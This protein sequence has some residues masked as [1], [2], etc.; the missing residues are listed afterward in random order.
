MAT[1]VDHV[2]EGAKHIAE[3]K[4]LQK[5]TR[6]WMCCLVMIMVTI[7]FIIVMTVVKPW[8]AGTA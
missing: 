5:N 4:E 6:K 8:K 2:K 3:A 7:V 1:S